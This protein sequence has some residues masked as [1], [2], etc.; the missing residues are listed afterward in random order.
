MTTF[1]IALIKTL[2][3]PPAY[4]LKASAATSADSKWYD[5][6]R[7]WGEYAQQWENYFGFG[8]KPTQLTQPTSDNLPYDH[9]FRFGVDP[10]DPSKPHAPFGYRDENGNRMTTPY[11]LRY[12]IQL[13]C[14]FA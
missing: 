8:K 12:M 4:I 3:T 10:N 5:S 13:C 14:P 7:S 2:L 11:V 6:N 1:F 9:A